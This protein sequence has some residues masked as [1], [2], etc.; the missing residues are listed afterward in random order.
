MAELLQSREMCEQ[1][2]ALEKY[3]ETENAR[4][5]FNGVIS[6]EFSTGPAVIIYKLLYFPS[7]IVFSAFSGLSA[8]FSSPPVTSQ[9]ICGML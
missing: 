3:R 1:R 9:K 2:N 4:P 7:F 5:T 6:V 8:H